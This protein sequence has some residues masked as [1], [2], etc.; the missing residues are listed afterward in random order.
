MTAK[1]A[2]ELINA[3]QS[4]IDAA[5]NT[6]GDHPTDQAVPYLLAAVTEAILALTEAVLEADPKDEERL[7]ER[8]RRVGR[9]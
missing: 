5:W 6:E 9:Q 3:A 2:R 8:L 1:R 4:D 7:M